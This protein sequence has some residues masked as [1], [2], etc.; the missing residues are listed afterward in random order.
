MTPSEA[1]DAVER[2]AATVEQEGRRLGMPGRPAV[3]Y[4]HDA[5]RLLALAKA[6]REGRE[7]YELGEVERGIRLLWQ[8]S[9]QR[10]T[11]AYLVISLPDTEQDG[12]EG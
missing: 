12:K 9:H 3:G 10:I 4:E 5:A 7:G 11:P 8:D 1:A 2:A 6:L